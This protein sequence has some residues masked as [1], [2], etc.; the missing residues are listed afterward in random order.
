LPYENFDFDR[1]LA[2]L[3][4]F[5]VEYYVAYTPEAREKADEHAEMERVAVSEPFA[6]YRL[7]DSPLVE[8]ASFEPS[9][10]DPALAEG[11]EDYEEVIVD[12]YANI[13]L[14][15]RWVAA[16]G[17][18]EWRRV[19]PALDAGLGGSCADRLG[20]ARSTD[21]VSRT[22]GFRSPPTRWVCPIS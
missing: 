9:V 21:I 17:P 5:G 12:W 22:T 20:E 7:P 1:G 2:H 11:A 13:D 3:A 6:V 8:V 15:D 4:H 16:D 14:L 10:Y 18:A 19:G